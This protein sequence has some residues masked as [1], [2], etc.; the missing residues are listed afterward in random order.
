MWMV[1]AIII[2]IL[3]ITFCVSMIWGAEHKE[4]IFKYWLHDD[5]EE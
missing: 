1:V 5:D 2:I 3:Q 4:D